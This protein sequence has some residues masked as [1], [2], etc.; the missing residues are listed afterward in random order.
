MNA[1]I[2]EKCGNVLG[3]AVQ[4]HRTGDSDREFIFRECYAGPRPATQRS[5]LPH[6]L[7]LDVSVI[8]VDDTV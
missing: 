3:S 7:R 1:S 8:A 2:L 4:T 5:T 6:S